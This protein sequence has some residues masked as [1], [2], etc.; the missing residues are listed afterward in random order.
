MH[1]L[2]PTQDRAEDLRLVLAW[3][4]AISN[5]PALVKSPHCRK[6]VFY[7]V[8]KY[9]SMGIEAMQRKLRPKE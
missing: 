5:D 7:L 6:F 9:G 4:Q 2:D 8:D 1:S 3:R